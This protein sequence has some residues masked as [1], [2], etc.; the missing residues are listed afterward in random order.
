MSDQVSEFLGE[1][2][3]E[4]NKEGETT[5]FTLSSEK[6]REKLQK[7]ALE[8]PENYFL[9][10]LA[11]LHA[12][13]AH[14][15]SLRV[16]ADDMELEG[17]C[18]IE[19]DGLKDLW[20][21]VVGG[22]PSPH[23]AGL[24][25]LALAMLTSVRFK[26]AVWTIDGQDDS[27][28]YTFTQSIQRGVL[29]DPILEEAEI[30]VE[31]F[32]V[33]LKRKAMGQVASR[34][35]SQLKKS[36][37][38]QSLYEERMLR[39]RLF[40]GV[41]E[42]FVFNQKPLDCRLDVGSALA[43]LCRGEAPEFLGARF[44]F[45]DT[46][47]F[48]MVAVVYPKESRPE[49]QLGESATI[50]WLWHGLKMGTTE[51]GL[52]YKFARV[53][54]VADELQTDLGFSSIAETW[55][56]Q[57]A[58]RQARDSIRSLLEF[59]VQEF[60]SS[61]LADPEHRDPQIEPILLEAIAER[62]DIRRSRKRLASFN[63]SLI[64]CPLFWRSDPDG[65][66]RRATLDELW[67]RAEK[68]EPI[69]CFRDEMDWVEVPAWP[70]RPPVFRTGAE[71]YRVLTKL[72]NKNLFREATG[73]AHKLSDI[74]AVQ[75]QDKASATVHTISDKVEPWFGSFAWR[76]SQVSWALKFPLSTS[77]K[78]RLR[79]LRNQK[80][81][82]E[83]ET[84][85]L[86]RNLLLYGELPVLPDYNGRLVE[87]ERNEFFLP[88]I[89]CLAEVLSGQ[90]EVGPVE[91]EVSAIIWSLLAGK[92]KV[93]E[94]CE[95][96]YETPW[97]IVGEPG[98]PLAVK[99]PADVFA[100]E[101]GCFYY[102]T[103]QAQVENL[104][105]THGVPTFVLPSDLEKAL[106]DSLQVPV[107]SV[108]GLELLQARP[109]FEFDG[110]SFEVI[111]FEGERARRWDSRLESIEVGIPRW[112][113]IPSSARDIA[114]HQ[115]L[116]GHSLQMRTVAS[117]FS[118]LTVCLSWAEGMPDSRGLHFADKEQT[119]AGRELAKEVALEAAL[120]LFSQSEVKEFIDY[121]SSTVE[122]FWLEL[123]LRG[124]EFSQRQ[125]FPRSDGT[126]VSYS[127]ILEAPESIPYFKDLEQYR[128]YAEQRALWVPS[129]LCQD[130]LD[131][132]SELDWREVNEE[133]ELFT[134]PELVSSPPDTPV[135]QKNSVKKEPGPVTEPTA[136]K[137]VDEG[138]EERQIVP[139][140]VSSI[141]P[142]N[143]VREPVVES[144]GPVPVEKAQKALYESDR[145]KPV[146]PIRPVPNA[147]PVPLSSVEAVQELIDLARSLGAIPFREDFIV[148]L[149]RVSWDAEQLAPLSF[150][151]E[152]IVLGGARTQANG[153]QSMLLSALYSIF[154][155]GREDVLDLHER[156]FHALLLEQSLA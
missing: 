115:N 112:K 148:F 97:I 102:T 104:E 138:G 86:P 75:E 118:P 136:A 4:G 38:S 89:T 44:Q 81:L 30:P 42:S 154:N 132:H 100:E 116:Q 133:Q 26:K 111:R 31:S 27:G 131:L 135:E 25:V 93:W 61:I 82:F 33:S 90:S 66:S 22:H 124:E 109:A 35:F 103:P 94:G 140:I 73:L 11:S 24:R 101:R 145:E 43:V 72:F 57:A 2:A 47:E 41:F 107:H 77:I 74:V 60:T 143:S 71:E 120:T 64:H 110:D 54:V 76:D 15:F 130:I 88:S 62:I 114:L 98:E 68:G 50:H 19:R 39:D 59:L 6:A 151:E 17:D 56:R 147:P 141:A 16:D 106:G 123:W 13:G 105:S 32:R 95:E 91:V 8:H 20:S 34:F 63:R 92:V 10:V 29:A 117:P 3:V 78:G 37:L 99:S 69:Y 23:A 146:E 155:R 46:G 79:V 21:H 40:I 52:S 83:D 142:P 113:K 144:V 108:R 139:P 137:V 55:K 119:D 53:F 65:V 7:F 48:P 28:A 45:E 18:R 152:Q 126:R 150:S 87:E 58:I 127:E 51:L 36:L 121:H 96:I 134:K 49:A 1:L 5:A 70:D 9:L 129:A 156:E 67:E 80:I 153:R 128:D 125:L 14:H 149:S 12:L 85:L 122:N 84:L